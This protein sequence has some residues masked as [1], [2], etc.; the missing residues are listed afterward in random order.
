MYAKY[1]K[2]KVVRKAFVGRLYYEGEKV[3]YFPGIEEN[4]AFEGIGDPIVPLVVNTEEKPKSP[5]RNKEKPKAPLQIEEQTG[6]PVQSDADA[7]TP[8]QAAV[9]AE[10]PN[11]DVAGKEEEK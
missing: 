9:S 8:E 7:E 10:A 6:V 11:E 2:Y 5:G 3:D 4:T 1:T